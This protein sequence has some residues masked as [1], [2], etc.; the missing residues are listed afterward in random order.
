MT[1]WPTASGLPPALPSAK[2]QVVADKAGAGKN[3]T[4]I[5]EKALELNIF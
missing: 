1:R 3:T 2:C 4:P 5:E